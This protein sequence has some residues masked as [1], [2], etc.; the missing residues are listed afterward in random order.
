MEEMTVSRP[1]DGANPKRPRLIQFEFCPFCH[2]VRLALGFKRIAYTETLARF[3]RPDPFRAISDFD[4]LPDLVYGD[5]AR[6]GESLDI[7]RSLD[8][9]FPDSGSLT[10]DAGED[11]FQTV[12]AWRARISDSLFRLIS[13]VLP[14]VI[15]GT[16]SEFALRRLRDVGNQLIK[17]FKASRPKN[18]PVSR[19]MRQLE[20]VTHL[21]IHVI[22]VGELPELTPLFAT[23]EVGANCSPHLVGEAVA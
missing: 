13:P 23:E 6:Q 19:A 11:D 18:R 20:F 14:V 12:L 10:P 15:P 7:I 21:E 17:V 2:R 16:L 5:G 9:R 1:G 22:V 3:Y 4:R 8:A